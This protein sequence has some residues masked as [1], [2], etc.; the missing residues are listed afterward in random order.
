MIEIESQ[1]WGEPKQIITRVGPK[2][3]KSAVP[4]EA[5]WNLWREQKDAL[6]EAGFSL[7][8]WN[9]GWQLSWWE[10][11]RLPVIKDEVEAIELPELEPLVNQSKLYDWQIPI[12]RGIVTAMKLHGVSMNGCETGLGK[13]VQTLAAIRERG[14]KAL[15]ICPKTITPD[16]EDA[17]KFMGV[18]YVG[19]YGWEWIKTG[20]TPFVKWSYKRVKRKSGD[21]WVLVDKK[22]EI[23]WTISDP[24][25]EVVIDE[26]H[27]SSGMDTQNCK[28]IM[29]LKGVAPAYLLSATL[30]DNPTK[31]RAS[32][33]LLGLHDG[34]KGYY[35]WMGLHGVIM[36]RFGPQFQG[37]PRHLKAIHA[38]IFPSK[39]VRV[40]KKELGDR[41]PSTQIIA[42]AYNIDEST[43]IQGVY[44]E[45]NLRIAE[46][47]EQQNSAASIL[48]EIIR[49]RQ[50][51]ELLKIPLMVSR[52]KDL[53]EEGNSVFL[54]V[55][56]RET[57]KEL[58][59]QLDLQSIIMGGQ[60]PTD[61]RAMM[62]A[63]QTNKVNRIGGIIQACREGLNLHDTHKTHP[64]AS[65]IMPPQSANDLKQV[66][67]RIDRSGGTHTTQYLLYAAGTIEVNV[68]HGLAE[69]LDRLDLLLDG[70]LNDGIFPANY[71]TMR[72]QTEQEEELL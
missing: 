39:G 33:Y 3:V 42:K 1:P 6:K 72:P 68:C 25:I 67:G 56:F 66:L 71:S 70:N 5:F 24:L 51:V 52:C 20:K 41:I 55:N 62:D 53:N 15:I 4:N 11:F 17:C 9:G 35:D 43:E 31:M 69:K 18:E 58:I 64:R 16:W 65:L 37:G 57:L 29:K 61:R 63:F 23:E 54:A 46:L 48:A 7:G 45:M 2:M 12:A 21:S 13:T 26:A 28:L 27:R 8:K 34:H 14:K 36:T 19:I 49:A 10:P 30:A 38:A 32:G 44:D 22:D 40:K 50:R 59:R 60:K 47:Q